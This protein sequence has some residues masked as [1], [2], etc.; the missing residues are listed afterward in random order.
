MIGQAAFNLKE[1]VP[2]NSAYVVQ[3]ADRLVAFTA[4]LDRIDR[5]ITISPQIRAHIWVSVLI[6]R[7][8]IDLN[9][10]EI[11]NCINYTMVDGFATIVKCTAEGRALM[12]MDYQQI[13]HRVELITHSKVTPKQRHFAEDYI[14]A[15]YL[16]EQELEKVEFR[17]QTEINYY[18][19]VAE[20]ESTVHQE[21]KKFTGYHQRHH[22]IQENTPTTV[23]FY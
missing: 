2:D 7:A 10:A 15:Y 8:L 17:L 18:L 16:S 20:G 9:Q 5:N 13:I 4:I 21:A 12:S 19:L 14:R 1:I 23:E 22:P 11:V 6:S 3:I